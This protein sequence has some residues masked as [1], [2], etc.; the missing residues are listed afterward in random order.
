MQ[1]NNKAF[2]KASFVD[3]Y[4]RSQYFSPFH[5]PLLFMGVSS[6]SFGLGKRLNEQGSLEGSLESGDTANIWL[7]LVW[8]QLDPYGDKKTALAFALKMS[9][10]WKR[11]RERSLT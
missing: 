1:V 8:F 6:K 5:A 3:L 11:G 10:A 7:S 9:R 2:S 4:L